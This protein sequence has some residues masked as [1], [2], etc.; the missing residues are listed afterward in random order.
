SVLLRGKSTVTS[1]DRCF[2]DS[3]QQNTA[4]VNAYVRQVAAR[5]PPARVPYGRNV[6]QTFLPTLLR[7]WRQKG[8]APCEARRGLRPSTPRFFE[9]NRVKLFTFVHQASVA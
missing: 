9:K 1:S 5:E 8:F 6:P 7:F 2:T 4:F 3:I